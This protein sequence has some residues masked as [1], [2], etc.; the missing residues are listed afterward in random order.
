MLRLSAPVASSA[1]GLALSPWSKN[2]RPGCRAAQRRGRWGNITITPGT[3]RHQMQC[4]TS[5]I[6]TSNERQHSSEN[7]VYPISW[8]GNRSRPTDDTQHPH[9]YLRSRAPAASPNARTAVPAQIRSHLFSSVDTRWAGFD[10]MCSADDGEVTLRLRWLR[11][12]LVPGLG[13]PDYVF[14]APS[15]LRWFEDPAKHKCVSSFW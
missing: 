3:C 7:E 10:G 8:L 4:R 2:T 1:G 15:L 11:W 13:Y 14:G 12:G 5:N 6:T 9:R